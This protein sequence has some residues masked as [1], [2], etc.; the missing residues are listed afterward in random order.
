MSDFYDA[1]V[2]LL[3]SMNDRLIY[4]QEQIGNFTSGRKCD[5]ISNILLLLKNDIKFYDQLRAKKE[6]YAAKLIKSRISDARA[7]K[8]CAI[9]LLVTSPVENGVNAVKRGGKA[10]W[11]GICKL[12]RLI[13]DITVIGW[14]M[15]KKKK[16]EACP[17]F[18][19]SDTE[20]T[21]DKPKV[22]TKV[23]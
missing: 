14:K 4:I 5:E 11:S 13:T 23:E 20:P 22:D 9:L 15:L 2:T 7:E 8:I 12:F 18:I 21:T 16:S 1:G 19:F 10:V 17:Y 6:I 3:P